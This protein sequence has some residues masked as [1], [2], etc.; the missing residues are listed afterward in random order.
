M[1]C[2]YALHNG[3]EARTPECAGRT[4]KMG[5]IAEAVGQAAK[6]LGERHRVEAASE[7]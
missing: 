2:E 3:P 6:A 5:R 4:F 1:I 7:W